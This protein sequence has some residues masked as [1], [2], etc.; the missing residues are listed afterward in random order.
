[1]S[2]IH[3]RVSLFDKVHTSKLAIKSWRTVLDW[4]RLVQDFYIYKVTFKDAVEEDND[5]A[6]FMSQMM[7]DKLDLKSV[8]S[9]VHNRD[10]NETYLLVKS[11]IMLQSLPKN[12]ITSV[13]SFDYVEETGL[14][15]KLLLN[16]LPHLDPFGRLNLMMSRGQLFDLVTDDRLSRS[17][18]RK[19]KIDDHH[20]KQAAFRLGLDATNS[21]QVAKTSFKPLPEGFL[22]PFY[23]NE[24]DD[25]E[26]SLMDLPNRVAIVTEQ[27]KGLP[28]HKRIGFSRKGAPHTYYVVKNHQLQN[29]SLWDAIQRDRAGQVVYQLE[30][31]DWR[32]TKT[33]F[34]DGWNIDGQ[35]STLGEYAQILQ[36]F[37]HAWQDYLKQPLRYRAENGWHHL[38]DVGGKFNA[39][40]SG[41][42]HQLMVNDQL[43][44]NQ[45]Q[46]LDTLDLDSDQLK[47]VVD[48]LQRLS[49]IDIQVVKQI[50]HQ[51]PVIVLTTDQSASNAKTDTYYQLG[52]DWI[53]T[54]HV[55]QSNLFT[56]SRGSHE[57]EPNANVLNNVLRETKFRWMIKHQYLSQMLYTPFD[58][59]AHILLRRFLVDHQGYWLLMNVI[60][61]RF[62]ILVVQENSNGLVDITRVTDLCGRVVQLNNLD[63]LSKLVMVWL[64]MKSRREQYGQHVVIS[65][66]NDI[67]G[68]VQVDWSIQVTNWRVLG[69]SY[70]PMMIGVWEHSLTIMQF[71]QLVDGCEQILLN[72]QWRDE[73]FND[74]SRI[75]QKYSRVGDFGTV[76]K[77]YAIDLETGKRYSWKLDRE[78]ALNQLVSQVIKQS[79]ILKGQR[80]RQYYNQ[81]MMPLCGVSYRFADPTRLYYLAGKGVK[82]IPEKV[83]NL[84]RVYEVQ[85]DVNVVADHLDQLAN[86]MY[87]RY[88][89]PTVNFLFV[90][91]INL[92][93]SIYQKRH[94]IGQ[95]MFS[96]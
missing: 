7:L 38:N 83:D 40:Q 11:G 6:K 96:K 48:E 30:N 31:V 74:L 69:G 46:V 80:N 3:M 1:M 71:K 78:L 49:G 42:L 77:K 86:N 36:C 18:R 27:M 73:L 62:K 14:L 58:D 8:V 47:Q 22:L 35:L 90:K 66:S 16:A 91:L 67:N 70:W 84:P 29:L 65:L 52:L 19:L 28:W 75:Y 55:T 85:G 33:Q 68:H 23:D 92:A 50:N 41:V 21:L 93:I 10:L 72:F 9:L 26:L 57:L 4:Q 59:R 20:Y 24:D 56:Q 81:L 45:I 51:D 64:N 82:G 79:V 15:G 37:N 25:Y 94:E 43:P 63:D 12:F 34:G 44:L 54:Q 2:D 5:S 53:L 76:L 88:N 89:G 17:D 60:D 39:R 61:N 95:K 87:V 32:D 13:V